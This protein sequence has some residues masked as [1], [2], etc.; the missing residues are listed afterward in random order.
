MGVQLKQIVEKFGLTNLTPDVSIEDRII[1]EPDLSR[2]S[3]QLT[4]YFEHFA[5]SR[6]QLIGYNEYYY[7]ETLPEDVKEANFRKLLSY[8]DIPAFIF[9]RNLMPTDL[10]LQLATENQVPVFLTEA[11]TA[12]VT[13]DVITWLKR[14]LAPTISTHGVLMDIYGVGVLLTGESGVGKSETALELI[15]RGHRLVS[16]DVVDITKI[17]DDLLIGTAPAVTKH[18]IELRGIGIIDVKMLFGVQSVRESQSI[19]LVIK[20]EDWNNT[21]TYER[22]GLVEEYTEYL[23]NKIACHNIPIRPGR[24]LSMIVEAAAINHRQKAMGYNAAEELMR[25]VQE[26][27]RR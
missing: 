9:C 26:N 6:I 18:L 20:M 21:K 14:A 4:G 11:D 1:Y 3:L 2:P 23:G 10:F 12:T 17:N 13:A 25:R 19:D 22:M 15:K 7:A 8:R 27:L 5:D 24:N 16:D